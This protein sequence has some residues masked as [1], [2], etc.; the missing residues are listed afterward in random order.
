VHLRT[1]SFETT[2]LVF[3]FDE[4]VPII[5]VFVLSR[6]PDKNARNRDR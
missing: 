5:R 6:G 2:L 1:Y 4:V 3:V